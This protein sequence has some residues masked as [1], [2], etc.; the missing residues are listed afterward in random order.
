MTPNCRRSSSLTR[1]SRLKPNRS[2]LYALPR[3]SRL[4]S[5][6]RRLC[7]LIKVPS[8][9]SNR[10]GILLLRRVPGLI[11]HCNCALILIV[12]SGLISDGHTVSIQVDRRIVGCLG[13]DGNRKRSQSGLTCLKTDRH[14]SGALIPIARLVTN[15]NRICA[16]VRL[17]RLVS[18]GDSVG[19]LQIVARLL[20]DRNRIRLLKTLPGISPEDDLPSSHCPSRNRNSIVPIQVITKPGATD[21]NCVPRW[22]GRPLSAGCSSERSSWSGHITLASHA[23]CAD[24]A[25][26][27]GHASVPG[28]PSL[29]ETVTI[30]DLK[31]GGVVVERFRESGG[32]QIADGGD[33]EGAIIQ[34]IQGNAGGIQ[35]NTVCVLVSSAGAESNRNRKIALTRLTCTYADGNCGGPLSIV[36]GILTKCEST[37]ALDIVSSRVADCN[38]TYTLCPVARSCTDSDGKLSLTDLSSVVANCNGLEPL[39][40]LSG[41]VADGNR[42]GALTKVSSLKTNRNRIQTLGSLTC[43][44]SQVDIGRTDNPRTRGWI[45]IHIITYVSTECGNESSGTCYSSLASVTSYSRLSSVT[46]GPSL[47]RVTCGACLTSR[48]CVSSRSG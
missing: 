3:E 38:S 44:L 41:G 12:E 15:R 31:C 43:I 24:H 36:T 18:Y 37:S 8:L 9:I 29:T 42:T 4:V 22:A 21:S 47:T 26:K 23:C 39:V 1:L 7:A 30:S 28:R 48:S 25:S 20:A 27:S 40:E 46:S 17:S 33:I 13:A 34:R 10:D 14:G 35:N 11:S 6:C 19:A 32:D 5:H 45:P 2:C 16:L